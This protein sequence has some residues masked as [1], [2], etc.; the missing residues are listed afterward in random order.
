MRAAHRLENSLHNFHPTITPEDKKTQT[1]YKHAEN[2]DRG[3][4]IQPETESTY[5]IFYRKQVH[6][7]VPVLENN[8]KK[9]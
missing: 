7:R 2:V 1:F 8:C 4:F 6:R 3:A 5:N 9:E